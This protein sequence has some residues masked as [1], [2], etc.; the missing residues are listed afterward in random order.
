MLFA[1]ID[2]G[3]I[4]YNKC[5]LESK[6]NDVINMINNGDSE[7]KINK[8]LNDDASTNVKYSVILDNDYKT[9]E[10]YT[11]LPL[12]TPGLNKILD[13]PYKIEVKR[14]IYEQ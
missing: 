5:G 12:I 1:I 8:F 2:F 4:L 10:V 14:V 11:S 6:L 3:L 7:D 13:N 9:V